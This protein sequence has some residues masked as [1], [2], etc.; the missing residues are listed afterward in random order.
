[1]TDETPTPIPALA[2]SPTVTPAQPAPAAAPAWRDGTA[3]PTDNGRRALLGIIALL[4]F[5]L[6]AGGYFAYRQGNAAVE[7]IA[8]LQGQVDALGKR[9][10]ALESRPT[11]QPAPNLQ[12][13]QQQLAALAPL[14]Q[15]VAALEPLAQQVATLA[16][17]GQQLTPLQQRVDAL[18][19][20]QQRVDALEKLPQRLTDLENK[21]P[22]QATL[23]AAAQT[24][25]AGVSSRID[26]VA[27]RQDQLGTLEQS[28]MGK[29]TAQLAG[30]DT[31]LS[32]ATKAG[33]EITAVTAR[34]ARVAQLQAAGPALAAGRPLGAIEGA[35]PALAQFAS[36][37]PPTEASLRLSFDDAAA[38]AREAGMPPK[39]TTPFLARMWDRAQSGVV[40][41][42][43]DRVLVGDAVSGILEKAKRQLDAGDLPGTVALLD[44]LSGPAAAAIAPWRAQAQ[45]LI[46]ARAALVSAARG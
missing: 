36:K 16:T 32:A 18:E 38:H 43:G 41:R 27:A 11:P 12:P 2:T 9:A 39:D 23:D 30:L 40:V 25:I 21:P 28:D 29:V 6:L 33:S 14:P 4:L 19:K 26:G 1:M 5:L 3:G 42:E 35:P 45:S 10:G 46:D 22:A 34:Q 24:Q 15:R 20:L 44:G 37:A 7:Q 17:L 13:L 8:Q 31:R